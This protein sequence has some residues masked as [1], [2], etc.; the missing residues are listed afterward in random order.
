MWPGVF[1]KSLSVE[2]Q[3]SSES[4]ED[5]GQRRGPVNSS[6]DQLQ[7]LCGLGFFFGGSAEHLPVS[8]VVSSSVFLPTGQNPVN[9]AKSGLPE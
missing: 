4:L 8:A 1:P 2:S 6:F 7:L 5:S 9:Q 3:S